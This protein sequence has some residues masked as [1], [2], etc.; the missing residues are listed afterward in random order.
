ML[1]LLIITV[2]VRLPT[3]FGVKRTGWDER[4]YVVFAQTLDQGGV[5]G[6]R[7]WMHDYPTNES[8]QKSP[9]L[10]RIGFIVPAMLTCKILGGFN[11]DNLAWLSFG[12]GVALVLLGAQFAENLSGRKLSI[13]CGILLITSPLAAGLARRAMQDTF[14]ALVF[15]ACLYFFDQCWRRRSVLAHVSLGI[16]LCLALLTKESAL[17]LYPMM[18]IAAT[19]YYRAIKLRPS[20]WLVLPLVAAPLIY[21]L[22]EIGICGGIGNF[23]ETYRIYAS[24]QQTLDYT[25][26]YE[27]GPWFR[28]LLD[29]LA[30]APLVFIV[31][32]IGFFAPSEEPVRHGRNLALIY[33]AGG[34]LL[35]GQMPI[36]NVR[37]VLF[38]D[39]FLRLGAAVAIAHFA[40]Q[41][42][43]KLAQRILY[44]AVGLL[45]LTDAWQFYQVFVMGNVYSPTTF[46]LLRAEG[47]YDIHPQ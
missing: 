7:Q 26:H 41:W 36:V 39:M 4:A 20:R 40:T 25:V 28:Y 14:A 33:F 5:S 18:A 29:F 43:E 42:N 30:I 27:K 31:A 34:V 32:I 23:I 6:I 35:F 44:F 17:L 12:C 11:P 45:V 8:L 1:W 3:M 19:Y 13:L 15:L 38:V 22:I 9:L 46:L 24:L 37:L 2:A 10:L 47:F 21:L 16:C